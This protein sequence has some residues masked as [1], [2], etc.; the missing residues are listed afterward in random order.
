MNK[1]LQELA[2]GTAGKHYPYFKGN[3]LTLTSVYEF[4][5]GAVTSDHGAREDLRPLTQGLP[6]TT[7]SPAPWPS[8]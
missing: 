6:W 8:M 5:N 7:H 2:I 1:N 3:K 4:A